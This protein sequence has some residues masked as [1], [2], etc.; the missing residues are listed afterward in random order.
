ME[1]SPKL[2]SG[3]KGAIFP[4][5]LTQATDENGNPRYT[6]DSKGQPVPLIGWYPTGDLYKLI[7]HNLTSVLLYHIGERFRNESFGTRIYECLEE[8]NTQ[9]LEF[10]IKDFMKT[11]IPI[12]ESRVKSL[13]VDVLREDSKLYIRAAFAITGRS[14]ESVTLAYNPE[15]SDTY[16]Y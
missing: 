8:P 7:K 12:W 2:L 4:I 14:P 3:W 13:S 6:H 1:D 15:N 5:E 9:L 16:V 10:L 11:S